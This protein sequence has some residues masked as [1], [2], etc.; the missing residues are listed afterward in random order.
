MKIRYGNG[1]IA[2]TFT[3]CHTD[4]SMRIAIRGTDDV[5]ELRRVGATW[6]AEDCEV[7]IDDSPRRAYAPVSEEDCICPPDLAARLLDLLYTDSA[8][9]VEDTPCALACS[10]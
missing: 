6:V 10:A 5:L 2:E 1:Q 3:L 4:T 8:E 9:D 7:I